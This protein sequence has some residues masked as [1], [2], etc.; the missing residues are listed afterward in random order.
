M[1]KSKQRLFKHAFSKLEWVTCNH[2][3][4]IGM[5][6]SITDEVQ[7]V[8][9]Y[10]SFMIV[11]MFSLYGWLQPYGGSIFMILSLRMVVTI[12][13]IYAHDPFIQMVVSILQIH[14]LLDTYSCIVRHDH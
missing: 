7:V 9:S 13:R 11:H 6:Q 1:S 10:G 12:P 2:N 5:Q 14:V 3:L 8:W 4:S